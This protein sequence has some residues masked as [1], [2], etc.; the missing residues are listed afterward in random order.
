MSS[1]HPTHRRQGS[2]YTNLPESGEAVNIGGKPVRK[3]D[4][5]GGD[6]RFITKRQYSES[7]EKK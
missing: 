6:G 2:S 1:T 3:D 7:D 4:V 5:Y